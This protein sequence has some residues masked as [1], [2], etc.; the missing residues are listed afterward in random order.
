MLKL[1]HPVEKK[2]GDGERR[3]KRRSPTGSVVYSSSDIVIGIIDT[4][5]WP[6]SPSFGGDK[7]WRI[8]PPAGWNGTCETSKDFNKSACNGKIVGARSY[9]NG[10]ARD[11]FGHGTQVASIAAGMKVKASY[12]G[13]AA[14]TARGGSERSRIAVYNV[15][16][17][18]LGCGNAAILSAFD[19]AISDGVKVI[20]VSV[21]EEDDD[22]EDKEGLHDFLV[23]D[24]VSIGAF[25]AVERG[26]TVVCAGGNFGPHPG[27]IGND[28]PWIVTVASSTTDR[29]IQNHILLGEGTIIKGEALG[30]PKFFN[31]SAVYPLTSGEAAKE[32]NV[33]SEA[34]RNCRVG[35]LRASK[36]KG[37]IVFC[38]NSVGGITHVTQQDAEVPDK[39]GVGLITVDD[40]RRRVTNFREHYPTTVISSQESFKMKAYLNSTR[41]PVA[42]FLPSVTVFGYKPSPQPDIMAPGVDILAAWASND[43]SYIVETGTSMACPHV[44]GVAA[45]VKSAMPFLSPTGVKSAIMTTAFSTNNA[46]GPITTDEGDLAGPYDMGAGL[47]HPAGAVSPGL[48]YETTTEEFLHFLCYRGYNTTTVR[49][50]SRTASPSFCCPAGGANPDAISSLNYPSI[51]VGLSRRVCRA[52]R[53]VPRRLTNVA[54]AGQGTCWV[55]NVSVGVDDAEAVAVEVFPKVLRFSEIGETKEFKVRFESKQGCSTDDDAAAEK[56][57]VTGWIKWSNPHFTVRSVFV[58]ALY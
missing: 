29:E 37:K 45:N 43:Y 14:G 27:T 58:V 55:Y 56:K 12:E 18:D 48:V 44:S 22:D 17:P 31:R 35:T 16:D 10:S 52:T 4:G 2:V 20:S 15:C 34:A 57:V 51:S 41:K 13:L 32:R 21:G 39:G 9:V 42:T 3:V 7:A 5:I 1:Q 33:T 11:I 47:V 28:A 53:T 46:R 54:P 23:E 49:A 38:E 19:D 24:G 50:M 6:E 30:I 26:I 8:P 40:V 25:H 36:I